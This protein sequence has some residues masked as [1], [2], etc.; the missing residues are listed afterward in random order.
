[1]AHT[2]TFISGEIA[3]QGPDFALRHDVVELED[4]RRSRREV[5]QRPDEA[6]VILLQGDLCRV[7]R[8]YRGALGRESLELPAVALLPG[9]TPRQAAERLLVGWGCAGASLMEMG[10][11]LPSPG[12][13][14]E[15]VNMFFAAAPGACK[16]VFLPQDELL[17]AADTGGIDDM[18]T[19]A[20]LSL[21]RL[22]GLLG[23]ARP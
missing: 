12:I 9:E 10:T 1:M 11:I 4:G 14:Q 23:E 19:V 16:G 7:E 21:A 15:R 5:I 13:L 3:Y 17:T 20:A 8:V 2:E 22:R 18:K 6:M